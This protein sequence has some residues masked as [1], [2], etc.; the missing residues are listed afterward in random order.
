MAYS[1][2]VPGGSR[3]M[4]IA[5]SISRHASER[6][7]G[8]A[9]IEDDKPIHFKTFDGLIWA[10]SAYLRRAGIAPGDVVGITYPHSALYLVTLYALARIGA[11][12]LA[13]S[14]LDSQ[15]LRMAYAQ[16][17]GARWVVAPDPVASLADIPTVLMHK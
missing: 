2:V 5:D 3:I 4:N 16:R 15:V 12:S 13:L 10:A 17:F 14:V 11:V 6:P 1:A 8:V 9:L 7:Y